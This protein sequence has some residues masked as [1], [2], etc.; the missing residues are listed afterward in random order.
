MNYTKEKMM[1]VRANGGIAMT[2]GWQVNDNLTRQNTNVPYNAK[3]QKKPLEEQNTVVVSH[4]NG[5]IQRLKKWLKR[6]K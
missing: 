1:Q 5:W 3:A 6:K 4:E 2:N